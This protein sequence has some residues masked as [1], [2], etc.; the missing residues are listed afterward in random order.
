MTDTGGEGEDCVRMVEQLEEF[1][2]RS[3]TETAAAKPTT[4]P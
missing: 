3:R 2:D 1:V 4:H